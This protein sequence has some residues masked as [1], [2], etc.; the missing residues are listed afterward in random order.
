MESPLLKYQLMTTRLM[1][2]LHAYWRMEY[3]EAPGPK[4]SEDNP[5]LSMPKSGDDKAVLI[6][7]RGELNY[8]VMNKYPYNPGHLLV[9]PYREVATLKEMTPEERVEFMDLLIKGQEILTQAIKPHGFNV[10]IN[11]GSAAGAGIPSHI[12]CHIVPRWK[13]DTN[14]MPVIGETKVLPQSL[15]AMWLRLKEFAK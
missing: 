13:S 14:F 15:E 8:I 4:S 3:V 9:V 2:H 10:G 12:H 6:I 5:F 1:D 11:L 7:Y